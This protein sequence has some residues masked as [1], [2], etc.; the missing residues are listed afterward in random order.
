M[1]LKKIR[2]NKQNIF[3]NFLFVSFVLSRDGVVNLNKVM[4]ALLYNAKSDN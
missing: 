2:S 1:L 4:G 3:N